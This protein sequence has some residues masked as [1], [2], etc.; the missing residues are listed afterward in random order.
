M[1]P[2]RPAVRARRYVAACILTCAGRGTAAATEL[3]PWVEAELFKTKDSQSGSE[4]WLLGSMHFSPLSSLCA[5]SVVESLSKDGRLGAVVLELDEARW[6]R[7]LEMQP[8]GSPLR[9]LLDNEMQ[10]AAEPAERAG[11][12][13]VFGDVEETG[14]DDEMRGELAVAVGD[15]LDPLGGGWQRTVDGIVEGLRID[16]QTL[17]APAPKEGNASKAQETAVSAQVMFYLLLGTPLSIMKSFFA[18]MLD[19]PYNF[20]SLVLAVPF[21]VFLAT[22]MVSAVMAP[23]ASSVAADAVV[24]PSAATKAAGFLDSNLRLALDLLETVLAALPTLVMWRVLPPLI[25]KQRDGVL[26][27]AV[28]NACVEHGGGDKVVVVVLG[29]AHCN[30]VLRKLSA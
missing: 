16:G 15:L 22:S 23:A 3:P 12:P 28:R 29:K 8:P 2:P 10:S 5:G 19:A 4:V 25:L 20:V 17:A 11:V 9:W 18:L 21:L 7:T 24:D 14:F 6:N 1:A 13:V 30:G 26:A 27:E